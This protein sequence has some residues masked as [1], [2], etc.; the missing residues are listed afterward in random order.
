MSNYK[1]QRHRF[2]YQK[3]TTN[4][5]HIKWVGADTMFCGKETTGYNRQLTKFDP[6]REL[7]AECQAVLKAHLKREYKVDGW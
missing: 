1:K 3:T 7:C 2:A 4:Q 5:G 6:E